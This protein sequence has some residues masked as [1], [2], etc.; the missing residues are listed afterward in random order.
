[1]QSWDPFRTAGLQ[2]RG[3][4][5]SGTVTEI[6]PFPGRNRAGKHRNRRSAA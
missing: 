3:I 2:V 4:P 1:L 5:L 6:V